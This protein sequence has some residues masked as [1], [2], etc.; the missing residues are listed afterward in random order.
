MVTKIISHRGRTSKKSIDNTIQSVTNAIDL[1][2]DMVE[3]DVRKTKDSQIICF[4]DSDIG[5]VL[6]KDLNYSDIIKINA[7]IPTLEQILWS[8]KGKIGMEVELKESGYEAD[9]IAMV[10]DY[11]NYDEFVIKSFNYLTI[12]NVKEID[13]KVYTGLLLGSGYNMEQ[14][15]VVLYESFTLDKFILSQADF[16]S[17][18]YKIF[19]AGFLFKFVKQQVPIQVWTVNDTDSI[20]SLINLELH[21]VV[22]DIPETAFEIR[23]SLSDV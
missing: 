5:G 21:S 1:E 3:V 20:R 22:T 15:K 2:V 6:I 8:S 17:A 9:V 19:M 23:K 10:L 13:K 7:Q 16:I 11:F 14:L 4:H 12:K 18:Y